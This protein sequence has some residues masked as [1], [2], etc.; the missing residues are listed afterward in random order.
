MAAPERDSFMQHPSEGKEMSGGHE[1]SVE[2]WRITAHRG[3]IANC[4]VNVDDDDGIL[5]PMAEVTGK[6]ESA[7]CRLL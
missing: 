4:S 5:V 3:G 1:V 2:C 7:V 6:K